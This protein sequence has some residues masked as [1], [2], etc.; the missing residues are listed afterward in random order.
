MAYSSTL[1]TMW[2]TVWGNSV[3]ASLVLLALFSYLCFRRKYGILETL[4][5]LF[6]VIIGV[7]TADYLPLW[8]RG[9]FIMGIGGV[10]GLALTKIFNSLEPYAK[11]YLAFLAINLALTLSGYSLATYTYI[12]SG[13]TMDLSNEATQ[14]PTG[15]NASGFM[16]ATGAI[17]NIAV[18]LIDFFLG[19]GV[20]GLL[21]VSGLPSEVVTLVGYPIGFLALLAI[22]PLLRTVWEIVKTI[23]D[24]TVGTLAK[25]IGR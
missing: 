20:I 17:K 25:F 1:E 5:V 11:I 19:G 24:A 4:Y 8:V 21:I 9:I 15:A 22:L 14:Y 10:W 7:T 12:N 18:P 23:L 16:D 6:P 13:E 3:I 2:L